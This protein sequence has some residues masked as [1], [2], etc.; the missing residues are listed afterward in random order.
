MELKNLK[1]DRPAL[2]GQALSPAAVSEPR[3]LASGPKRKRL[4]LRKFD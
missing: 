3:A 1:I 2:V 4:E